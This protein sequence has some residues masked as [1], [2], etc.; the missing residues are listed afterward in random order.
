VHI[1]E[2]VKLNN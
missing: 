2:Q 1:E